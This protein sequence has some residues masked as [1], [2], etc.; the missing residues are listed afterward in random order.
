MSGLTGPR[1]TKTSWTWRGA[2]GVIFSS[3]IVTP[4]VHYYFRGLERLVLPTVHNACGLCNLT[5]PQHHQ[6]RAAVL[7]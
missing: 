7:W 5:L 1:V 2:S 6:N 4:A 3:G